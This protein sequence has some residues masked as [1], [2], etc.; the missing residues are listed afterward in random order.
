MHQ[1]DTITVIF[2]APAGNTNLAADATV[3]LATL[4]STLA[5]FSVNVHNGTVLDAGARITAFAFRLDPV[6][7]ANGNIAVTDTGGNSDTDAFVQGGS[8]D[9]IP[10]LNSE[11]VCFWSGNNCPG[12]GNTGLTDGQRDLFS[13]SLA[14]TFGSVVDISAIG[15]KWQGCAGCSFEIQGNTTQ[16]PEPDSLVLLGLG[17]M[18]AAGLGWNW[19]AERKVVS[20][21]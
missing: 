16:I 7:T 13:F 11:N 14:G 8:P 19:R 5:T 21:I 12:G 17:L 9:N 10:S 6:P 18:G 2:P 20:P 3:T 1:G 4:I 15:I